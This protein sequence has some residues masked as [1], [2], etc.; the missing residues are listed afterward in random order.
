MELAAAT[1]ASSLS[2]CTHS[3]EIP[4]RL[5]TADNRPQPPLTSR[6]MRIL[7]P[8]SC[9]ASVAHLWFEV[10]VVVGLAATVPAQ[11]RET[12]SP[13]AS[14][15]RRA[16]LVTGASSGI[17]R[18]TTELLTKH[19][20]F[21]YATARKEADLRE[22]GALADVQPIALD[23]TKPDQIDAAVKLVREAGRGLHGLVN[24]AGIA[25]MAPLIEVR[26][27]DLL[28]QFEVNVL[29]VVRVTRAFAPLLL[30]S[31]GR[32]VTTGSLS[33]TVNW[34]MGGPYTMSKHAV[35]A[36][37]DVLAMELQPFGVRVSIVEPGNYRS[38]IMAGMRQRLIDGGYGGKESRYERQIARLI[39]QPTDRAQYPEPHDVA[40]AFLHALT[41]DQQKRRY[42][43]VPNQREAE[44]TIKAAIARVVQL[45]QEHAFS[46]DRDT[47]VR[48]LDDALRTK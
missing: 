16:V 20:F 21:V 1:A 39:E 3:R 35:E 25:V 13:P 22:L 42:L 5:H 32:V 43:V 40:A 27:A 4:C 41:D 26:D 9:L 14:Q 48:F 18:T 15:T 10:A 38:E 19:G 36:F 23:V 17:G 24:N 2:Q 33:G 11:Q 47:L 46:Y 12:A 45:N 7:H 34:A 31:K 28:Q 6:T 8:A 37:T 30:E 29:G 44:L